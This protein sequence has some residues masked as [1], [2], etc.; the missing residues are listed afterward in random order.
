MAPVSPLGPWAPV[1]PGGPVAPV[2]PGTATHIHRAGVS[3]PASDMYYSLTL[4]TN[5]TIIQRL[6]L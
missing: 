5:T 4:W 3:T 1:G 2:D 6:H